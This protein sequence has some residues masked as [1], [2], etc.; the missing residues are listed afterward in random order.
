[1]AGTARLNGIMDM[2]GKSGELHLSG[3][4]VGRVTLIVDAPRVILEDLHAGKREDQN[5]RL[6]LVALGSDVEVRGEVEASV[7]L[8]PRAGSPSGR[9]GSFRLLS[10]ATLAG[11]LLSSSPRPD[12][13]RLLGSLDFDTRQL[14]PFPP[15]QALQQPGS[16]P[17][18]FVV[19]PAPI[20]LEGANS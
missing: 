11:N 19:S 12:S 16:G 3:N 2:R 13:I 9:S 4:P 15:S 14:N 6:T 7:I 18:V 5:D 8:L 17:Y 10:G 20:F 1:M